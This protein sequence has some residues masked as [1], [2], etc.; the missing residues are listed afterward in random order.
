MRKDWGR[1]VKNSEMNPERKKKRKVEFFLSQGKIRSLINRAVIKL[2]YVNS[3]RE[4]FKRA[5]IPDLS[6]HLFRETV[7]K[8]QPTEF[9]EPVELFRV[10]SSSSRE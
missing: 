9:Y 3:F 8:L 7:L 4:S 5:G 10:R 1:P 2:N 6:L